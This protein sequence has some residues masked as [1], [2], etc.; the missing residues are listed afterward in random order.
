[1]FVA[2]IYCCVVFCFAQQ[3]HRN[4]AL[5]ALILVE[6]DTRKKRMKIKLKNETE[7][8][9]KCCTS[10]PIK[11]PFIIHLAQNVYV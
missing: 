4:L 8:Q 1:M 7:K 11:R 6:R 3:H 5:R 9:S 2:G 10:K